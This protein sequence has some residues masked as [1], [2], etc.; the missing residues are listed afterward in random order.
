VDQDG[1]RSRQRFYGIA[2]IADALGVDRQLVTVWR[3]RR[4]RDLPRPDAELA[5]GPLWLGSTIEPWIEQARERLRR[6][7][8]ATR[9]AHSFTPSL[10]RQAARRAFRLA[11]LLLEEPRRPPQLRQALL[12]LAELRPR[13]E[14]AVVDGDAGRR[15]ARDLALLSQEAGAVA[16]SLDSPPPDRSTDELLDDLL[17]RCLQAMP[18]VARALLR[19]DPAA[20]DR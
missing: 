15:G 10:A 5:A 14:Q 12:A 19:P 11:A 17:A 13:L 9:A 20:A 16:A 4:S 1:A 6:E 18:Q 3:R 2:E 7:A 8:A